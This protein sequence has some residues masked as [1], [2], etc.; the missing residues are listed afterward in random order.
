MK[1]M[2]VQL[3]DTALA[4]LVM[5]CVWLAAACLVQCTLF[6][7]PPPLTQTHLC[8]RTL[9]PLQASTAGPLYSV[10]LPILENVHNSTLFKKAARGPTRL[11]SSLS[12]RQR[13]NVRYL[14]PNW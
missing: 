3:S 1:F 13:E 8:A 12:E 7:T 10:S 6:C 9:V 2:L 5:M 11:S 4:V 14:N